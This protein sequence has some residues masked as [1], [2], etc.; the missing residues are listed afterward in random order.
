VIW[1]SLLPVNLSIA[2]PARPVEPRM[3]PSQRETQAGAFREPDS[4]SGPDPF[5]SFRQACLA[6]RTGNL[7]EAESLLIAARRAAAAREAACLNLLGVLSEARGQ[8]RAARR[9]Y[10][11]AMRAEPTFSPAEQN[12]RRLYELQAFG[13]TT[14][15]VAVGHLRTDLWLAG[16][17]GEPGRRS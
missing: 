14:Y 8:T 12:I 6:L 5:G 3:P 11:R 10:G 16:L 17:T 7:D 15:P 13:K 2:A 9:L 4:D 1:Q